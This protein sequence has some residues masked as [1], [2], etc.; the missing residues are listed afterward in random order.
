MGRKPRTSLDQ[1]E[2]MPL[3]GLKAEWARLHGAPAPALSADLLRLGIAYRLQEQRRGGL[4][5]EAKSILRQAARARAVVSAGTDA[6][7]GEGAAATRSKHPTPRK[8][9]PG[10]RLVRDWHGVGHTVTVLEQG[11]AYAGREWRS[12]SAI[13]KAITGAHWNGPR[14]FGLSDGG[15]A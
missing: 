6:E 13:A 11:F 10:T 1:L 12:L 3:V 7:V 9:T 2:T 4:S 14:F 15:R 5:R 8:L